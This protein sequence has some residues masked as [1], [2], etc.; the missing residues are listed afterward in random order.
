MI[1]DTGFIQVSE[2]W[3]ENPEKISKYIW[4]VQIKNKEFFQKAAYKRENNLCCST[5]IFNQMLQLNMSK[6]FYLPS[7]WNLTLNGCKNL[8][9]HPSVF[10]HL[11]GSGLW[12]KQ[13]EDFLNSF[14]PA[15]ASS[16]Y[17]GILRHS[18]DSWKM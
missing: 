9:L 12:R 6:L 8:L 7:I 14:S 13:S 3:I 4:G 16:S 2:L 17:G 5:I 10:Y 11:S 1:G 15:T 18:Q